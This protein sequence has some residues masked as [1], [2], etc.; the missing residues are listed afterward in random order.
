M[1][2]SVRLSNSLLCAVFLWTFLGLAAP[3]RGQ[4]PL[5]INGIADKSTYNLQTWF[6]V[7]STAG[8]TY[9]VRL[10]GQ[11]APTDLTN[12]VTWADYHEV[13][14]NRTNV[15][16]GEISNVM[17]RFIV[18]SDRGSP[19]KGL[20]K[21]TPYP[22]VPSAAGEFAGARLRV[23]APPTFPLGL[24]I[25]LVAWVDDGNGE[26]RRAN[27]VITAP[28]FEA[29]PFP[30]KR[31]VG[32]LFLPPATTAG[33][34]TYDAHLHSLYDQKEIQIEA[35]TA[36]TSVSGVL[37]AS[38][39]WP[40]N[41]RIF[42]NANFT[43][44]AGLTLT[45]GP[46]TVIKL[47]PLVN[48]TNSGRIVIHGSPAE[49]VVMTATN[50]VLPERHAGAWGGFLLRGT[51]AELVANGTIFM[52]GGGATSFSFSPGA[53][54]RSE[55]AV[56]LV[57]SG[58]RAA[59][60]NCY[61]LNTAGQVANGYN[62]DVTYDHCLIQRAITC[63]EYV[64]GVIT[65]N[66]SALIEFPEDNGVVNAAIADAD[67]DGIYFTTGTH[68]LL[69][70]LFG[71]CKDDAIDS[72]SGGAGTVLVSNCWVEAA[73]HE[74]HAWSGG[75]RVT[76]TYDSVLMNSGQGIE[77]GWTEGSTDGSPNCF[78]DRLLTTG[79]S[80]GARFGDNYDWT[81]LGRL[82]LTNTLMLYN[83]RDIFLK[84]WNGTGSGWQTNSWVDRL[85]QIHFRS[86]FVSTP[87][88][89]QPGNAVW[90]PDQ[91]AWRLAHFMR[92]PP[93]AAVGAGFAV[94]TNQFAMTHLFAGVPV[95][96]STFTTNAVTVDY[97]F[98][99]GSTTLATGSLTFAP[100]ETVK[101]IYP[102]GFDVSAQSS[103]RVALTGARNGEVTGLSNVLF[104]GSAPAPGVS[105]WTGS[106]TL[107]LARLPEGLL[108]KLSAP[109]GLPVTVN[110]TY[111]ADGSP[112]ASG[113]LTFAPGETVQRISPAGV[114]AAAHDP[115]LLALSQ[116]VGASLEG[117]TW[118][119]YGTP[120]T[121]VSLGVSGSQLD[122]ATFSSGVP[123]TL[124]QPAPGTVT[125][126]F[127]CE[128]TGGVLTNGTLT[129][130]AGQSLRTLLLPTV[131]P[132]HHNLLSVTL[133]NPVQALLAPPSS[134][135]YVRMVAGQTPLLITSGSRWQYLDTG[136]DAG[137]AWRF[138]GYDDRNWS[139]GLAQLGFQDGDE[140][141]VIRR[142]GT[143][144]AN[145]ITFYFRQKF[146]VQNPTAFTNLALWL[147][148]DDGGVVYL[149]G[150]EVYRSPSMPAAPAVITYQTLAN[151]QG[152]SAPPD[153]TVDQANVS[154]ALLLTGTNLVA[155][156]IHQHRSDSSDVSFDF[157]LTGQP[158]PPPPPQPIYWGTFG[159]QP[160]L[161]WGNPAFILQQSDKVTG[162]WTN[163]VNAVSPFPVTPAPGNQFFR[164]RN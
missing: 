157:A 162:P 83:Y 110:Y 123:V 138:P 147:L 105:C 28:G 143:N 24:P 26:A 142:V 161:A 49:P 16:S 112:L 8:Y 160:V 45:I 104:T 152:S 90:N 145:T 59:L 94:W 164:L 119:I 61:I 11:P 153:N 136:G 69:N 17:V 6:R 154:P 66:H 137:T 48:I 60:T 30:V 88:T 95:R 151:A 133:A 91:D 141:T 139:N 13:V 15:V 57:H 47:N 29:H 99:S 9:D 96:L 46:G 77:A 92:T 32:S 39:D 158:T 126:D 12:W 53:S 52:G 159:G 78:A 3:G 79:N 22:L 118:V 71:F 80:V 51:S 73:L 62:S 10:N 84:T 25:P 150:T 124:N 82:R 125:V 21:W 135:M 93:E 56:F 103:V 115:I 31:G 120:P 163:V 19:E 85:G 100:G 37:A 50:L 107:P 101:L 35:S 54:H 2:H 4:A 70:S 117:F 38:T 33:L 97:A 155:V 149:N 111:S 7:P 108:V 106:N 102:T 36:W 18:Q 67:Y 76:W 14:V 55:Q 109:A 68:L 132:A 1:F 130:S 5:P 148:R 74:A 23:F 122:L 64:G 43:V 87:W 72:G 58:A 65:V 146:V 86:N 128:G 42:I 156:E 116:P 131:N 27:G 81:Y 129:F 127:Q 44:P 98:E 134:V 113:T 40:A 140:A 75:G 41:S 89:D 20:I 34:L 63:G 144:G 114:N 121:L